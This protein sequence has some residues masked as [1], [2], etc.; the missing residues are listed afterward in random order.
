MSSND[1]RIFGR[2]VTLSLFSSFSSILSHLR[3]GFSSNDSFSI[4]SRHCIK[5]FDNNLVEFSFYLSFI[6]IKFHLPIDPDNDFFILSG[7]RDIFL[8]FSFDPLLLLLP[9][10]LPLPLLLPLPLPLPLLLPL[11]LE[12]PDLD[13]LASLF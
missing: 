7:D 1:I 13:F 9:L 11:P 3:L 8:P 5:F 4:S 10:P 2:T 12:L 6:T